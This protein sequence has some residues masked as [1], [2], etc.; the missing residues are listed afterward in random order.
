M[1]DFSLPMG[2]E[3]GMEDGASP[4]QVREQQE[5]REKARAQ[6]ADAQQRVKK[7]RKDEQ[8]TKKREKSLAALLSAFI[9]NVEGDKHD[10]RIVNTLVSLLK[11]EIPA[12][13]PVGVLTLL[14]PNLRE[15]LFESSKEEEVAMAQLQ[16]NASML[17]VL[18]APALTSQEQQDFDHDKL[19]EEVKSEINLWVQSLVLSLS[20]HPEWII[21]RVYKEGRVHS[22]LV[23]LATFVLDNF[24]DLYRIKGSH[25]QLQV[26][27]HFILEG[28]L[29]RASQ[30]QIENS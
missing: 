12:E 7:S 4:E 21:P 8:Q 16:N 27:V 1:E 26:F 23:Q 15:A 13:L 22:S 20:F 18:H 2:P 30:A 24:L 9:K 10:Q 29:K 3:G 19:P 14:Y 11:Q 5:K 6:F 17:T 28:T 25:E